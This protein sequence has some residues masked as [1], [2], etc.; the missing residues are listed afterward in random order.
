MCPVPFL[1]MRVNHW[2]GCNHPSGWGGP[3]ALAHFL[4]F[5]LVYLISCLPPCVILRVPISRPQVEL[6]F[7]F[8]IMDSI[9][10]IAG[11]GRLMA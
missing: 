8:C 1:P 11:V 9:D 10:L 5:H 6:N 4:R 2:D 7:I 3:V